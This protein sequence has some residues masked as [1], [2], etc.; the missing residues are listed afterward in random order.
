MAF[1][2]INESQLDS[3]SLYS[4]TNVHCTHSN[5]FR[6]STCKLHGVS[7]VC[8][9]KHSSFILFLTISDMT[10]KVTVDF[11]Q[12]FLRSHGPNIEESTARKKCYVFKIK[13]EEVHS[14]SGSV[15]LIPVKIVCASWLYGPA[16]DLKTRGII[17]P[18]A[19]FKCSVPCPCLRCARKHHTCRTPSSEA[20]SCQDCLKHFADHSRFHHSLHVGCKFCFQIVKLIPNFNFY[21]LDKEKKKFTVGIY[22]QGAPSEHTFDVPGWNHTLEVIRKWKINQ[23]NWEDDIDDGSIWCKD[24]NK[25]FLCVGDLKNHIQ[26]SHMGSKIFHHH[27]RNSA[28]KASGDKNCDKCKKSFTTRADL[29]RHEDSIHLEELFVCDVCGVNFTR[30]DSYNRHKT[31]K[32]KTV[33]DLNHRC[34]LCGIKFKRRD[35]LLRHIKTVH[36]DEQGSFCCNICNTTFNR[37]TNFMRHL[38]NLYSSEGN[39]ANACEKCPESFCTTSSLKAHLETKH[40]VEVDQS[41]LKNQAQENATSEV[42]K[43]LFCGKSFVRKRNLINH[44]KL[45]HKDNVIDLRCLLCWR[46]FTSKANLERHQE[47]I[48]KD[49]IAKNKCDNCGKQFCTNKHMRSHVNS[50]HTQDQFVCEYCDQSFITSSNL[51]KHSKRRLRASLSCDI[52]GKVMCNLKL[53]RDHMKKEHDE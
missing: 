19:R 45:V 15:S 52:C 21:F 31:N 35:I 53:L 1:I 14:G 42:H 7:Q 29:R 32:H 11:G 38:D 9:L 40:M 28:G 4:C 51:T 44:R 43:C 39:P 25:W 26:K 27:C 3:T 24:C 2:A 13:T 5:W 12:N 49:G 48:Y 50:V 16:T 30:E 23:R 22:D 41:N 46:K 18:C 6:P 36:S 33:E 8:S 47:E 17:Y 37:K 34:D 10:H 20:C